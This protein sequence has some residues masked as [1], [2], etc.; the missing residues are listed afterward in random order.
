MTE[1]RLKYLL[2]KIVADEHHLY[3]SRGEPTSEYNEVCMEF[4]ALLRCWHETHEGRT[5]DDVV[6]FLK[7]NGRYDLGE[8]VQTLH[9]TSKSTGVTWNEI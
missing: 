8:V 1:D 9:T 3:P 5:V 2:A 6:S 7:E 4:R